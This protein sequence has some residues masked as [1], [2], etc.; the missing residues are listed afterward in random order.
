MN[1][2]NDRPLSKKNIEFGRV[3]AADGKL[4][5]I[6]ALWPLLRVYFE[7]GN[8]VVEHRQAVIDAIDKELEV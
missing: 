4:S 2:W 5:R 8:Y 1:P 6:R 3:S 7:S